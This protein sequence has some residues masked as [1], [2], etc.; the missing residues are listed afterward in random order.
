MSRSRQITEECLKLEASTETQS[1]QVVG[2]AGFFNG[3]SEGCVH[4]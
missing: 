2:K 3:K 4:Q 1:L